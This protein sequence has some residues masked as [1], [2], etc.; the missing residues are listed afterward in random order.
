MLVKN[1]LVVGDAADVEPLVV[2]GQ[3]DDRRLE[4][5]VAHVLGGLGGVQPEDPHAHA[6]G[7]GGGTR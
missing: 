6:A 2:D 3:R 5:P 7:G 4:P 1:E